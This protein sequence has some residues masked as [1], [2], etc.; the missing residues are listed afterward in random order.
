MYCK[1]AVDIRDIEGAANRSILALFSCILSPPAKLPPV[2]PRLPPAGLNTLLQPAP[3][4]LFPEKRRN[5][6]P[7][8]SFTYSN[9]LGSQR[10]CSVHNPAYTHSAAFNGM[11]WRL[12]CVN[13]RRSKRGGQEELDERFGDKSITAP[14]SGGWSQIPPPEQAQSTTG[15]PQPSSG[16]GSFSTKKWTPAIFRNSRSSQRSGTT[17]ETHD[18]T[19]PRS[20]LDA[21]AAGP[22]GDKPAFVYKP[23][24]DEFY[25]TIPGAV[26]PAQQLAGRQEQQRLSRI[27]CHRASSCG[28]DPGRRESYRAATLRSSPSPRR[29][30]QGDSPAS[31]RVSPRQPD[32]FAHAPGSVGSGSVSGLTP[33]LEAPE[34]VHTGEPTAV[35]AIVYSGTEEQKQK[36][37]KRRTVTQELVPPTS[38]LFG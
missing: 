35:S 14:I 9:S 7:A 30:S 34:S 2:K 31:F 10:C 23:A 25:K 28:S 32:G 21:T 24:S 17:T 27:S 20:D 12:C 37:K 19:T 29:T 33:T 11:R 4:T 38:E 1:R 6:Q 13:M 18:Q 15:S 36:K 22:S 26:P 3:M 8:M 5:S 16:D